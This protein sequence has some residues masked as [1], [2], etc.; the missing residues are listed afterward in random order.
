MLFLCLNAL[1]AELEKKSK[2][3]EIYGFYF[4]ANA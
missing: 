2:I 1:P 4:M 3:I